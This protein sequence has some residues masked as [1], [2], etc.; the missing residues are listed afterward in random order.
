MLLLAF[1]ACGGNQN[2]EKP[3]E[4]KV[5]NAESLLLESRQM[6]AHFDTVQVSA[7]MDLIAASN[8]IFKVADQI[9]A[10]ISGGKADAA[11]I[12]P[13]VEQAHKLDSILAQ[14]ADLAKADTTLSTV[15]IDNYAAKLVKLQGKT[16]GR[17]IHNAIVSGS[18]QAAF[19]TVAAQTPTDSIA[20]K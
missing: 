20:G 3:Y 4:Y 14:Q 13:L 19:E 12:S 15:A 18:P 5:D 16:H 1:A 9:E 10:E 6:I 11:S 17:A 2:E 7:E 8:L